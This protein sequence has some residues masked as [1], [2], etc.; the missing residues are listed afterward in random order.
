[1]VK[2]TKVND[3]KN[4]STTETNE[5]KKITVAAPLKRT[6]WL[7]PPWKKGQSGN[8]KWK[9]KSVFTQMLLDMKKQ[10]EAVTPEQITTAYSIVF[11]YSEEQL[12]KAANDIKMPMPIR[13]VAKEILWKRWF[14]IIETM[15]DRAHGKAKQSIDSNVSGS[16]TL[17]WS[18][19]EMKKIPQKSEV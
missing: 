2:K 12:K 13:I 19:L 15:L 1:M 18:L 11:S 10:G 7:K 6:R 9:P 5:V 4:E 3:V 8:P 17:A 16:L 14:D